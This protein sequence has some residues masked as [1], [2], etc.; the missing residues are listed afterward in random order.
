MRRRN[1]RHV[2]VNAQENMF[3]ISRNGV[4]HKAPLPLHKD[5]Y[6]PIVENEEYQELVE[7]FPA[8]KEEVETMD[9][10]S[11]VEVLET[12]SSEEMDKWRKVKELK[13]NAPEGM[14]LDHITE[15]NIELFMDPL[16]E[17]GLEVKPDVPE[18]APHLFDA[19]GN[20]LTSA[21]AAMISYR[22]EESKLKNPHFE[23][24][25]HLES[26]GIAIPSFDM[27]ADDTFAKIEKYRQLE[28]KGYIDVSNPYTSIITEPKHWR[29]AYAR[30]DDPMSVL[31]KDISLCTDVYLKA[32]KKADIFHPEGSKKQRALEKNQKKLTEMHSAYAMGLT[33]ACVAPLRGGLNARNI[34][35]SASMSLT[36]MAL[37]P[38]YRNTV[39]GPIRRGVPSIVEAYNRKI[40]ALQA[41]AAGKNESVEMM[42]LLNGDEKPKE[43]ALWKLRAGFASSDLRLERGDTVKAKRMRRVTSAARFSPETAAMTIVGLN[44]AYYDALRQ[45]MA[46]GNPQ[47][48]ERQSEM[49][50]K[51]ISSVYIDAGLDGISAEDISSKVRIIIG[52]RIMDDPNYAYRYQELAGTEVKPRIV[53]G[54]NDYGETK[55]FITDSFVGPNGQIIK[56]GEFSVRKPQSEAEH[57]ARIRDMVIMELNCTYSVEEFAS[58]LRDYATASAITRNESFP[59]VPGLI[60]MRLSNMESLREAYQADTAGAKGK[61]TDFHQLVMGGLKDAVEEVYAAEDG[62]QESLEKWIG[63]NWLET[64]SRDYSNPDILE[65]K[66]RQ[67]DPHTIWASK[68]PQA[69]PML[70]ADKI[71]DLEP[72]A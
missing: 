6:T 32:I 42:A 55:Q 72:G 65:E 60:G 5:G 10:D 30:T 2:Q 3:E 69:A 34:V 22:L 54:R 29:S 12:F 28:E 71:Y 26:I 43:G 49:F 57:Q 24:R 33:A 7:R 25:E 58:V 1:R 63:K 14:N 53:D 17:P 39:I 20:P 56:S 51:M 50:D 9:Y 48:Q 8:L 45:P 23:M 41:K 52:Q 27:Y 35:R 36:L 4:E 18:G 70:D 19:Q 16:D 38:A 15:E 62:R 68:D 40:E 13:A 59:H 31:N 46:I 66:Y 64:F 11:M 44:D 47:V 21:D 37:N 61:S 67:H